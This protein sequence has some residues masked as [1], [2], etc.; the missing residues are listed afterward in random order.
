MNK[1]DDYHPARKPKKKDQKP[2]RTQPEGKVDPAKAIPL[3][4]LSEH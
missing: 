1:A 4:D 3:P 2:T